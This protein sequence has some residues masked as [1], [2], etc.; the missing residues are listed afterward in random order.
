[1]SALVVDLF[2]GAM[3]SFVAATPSTAPMTLR[4][5]SGGLPAGA[6]E[7]IAHHLIPSWPAHR[8]PI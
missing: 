3:A 2:A 7:E 5:V 6:V 8:L 4:H 1:M